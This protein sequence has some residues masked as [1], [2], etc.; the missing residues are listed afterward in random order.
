MKIITISDTHG[1]EKYLDLPAGDMIIFSG[2]CQ[3]NNASV[4]N[5]LNW[6]SSL[7]YKYKI[8]IAGNHDA[9]FETLGYEKSYQLCK[10][11][12]IVYLQ[13]TSI[14]INGIKIHGSP[15]T[16]NFYNW[17]FMEDDEDLMKY[18]KLIPLDTDILIT[19]GPQY[20][21]CDKVLY[22]FGRDPNVGSKTLSI[23]IQK[24]SKLSYHIFG[25]IHEE[26]GIFDGE[27]ISLNSSSIS[28]NSR[29]LNKP[30]VFELD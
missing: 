11:K 22:P 16:P 13:D 9:V 6:M 2:D 29:N 14:V 27:Y 24:L 30:H 15:W 7:D 26:Y 3:T 19:H 23:A 17:S 21:V 12:G 8:I 4:N 18:W 25:H 20:G 10:E 28:F 5:F 1:Q